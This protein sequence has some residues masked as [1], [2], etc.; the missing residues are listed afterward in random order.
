MSI[1]TRLRRNLAATEPGIT[2]HMLDDL[3]LSA[4]TFSQLATSKP[5][6]RGRVVAMAEYHGL[7]ADAV[8]AHRAVATDIAIRCG[9]CKHSKAC[10]GWIDGTRSFDVQLCPN[11]EHFA[12]IAAA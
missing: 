11:T 1:L 3:G 8:D 10:Q 4:D 2:A 5:G 12:D 9:H 7:S 6:A